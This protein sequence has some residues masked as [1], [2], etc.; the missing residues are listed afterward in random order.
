MNAGHTI[1]R[2]ISRCLVGSALWLFWPAFNFAQTSNYETL[3][4]TRLQSLTR[5]EAADG[6]H[7]RIK[8]TVLCYDE[9]WHQLYIHDG[10][11]TAYISPQDSNDAFRP[12][13][14]VEVTGTALGDNTFTNLHFTILGE[15]P[16]PVPK[17]LGLSQLANDHGQWIETSGRV[18]SGETSRGRLALVLHD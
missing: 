11:G 12:G 5:A 3:A 14:S 9:G 17:R 15:Q 7:F 2:N 13:Q 16:V 1:W 8:G 6:F 10:S 18:L 4:A